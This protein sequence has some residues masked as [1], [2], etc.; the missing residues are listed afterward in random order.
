MNL[1]E[2][3][4]ALRQLRLSGMAQVLETR[5]LQ[6]QKDRMPPI[7][8]VASLEQDEIDVRPGRL[9]GRRHKQAGFGDAGHTLDNFDFAF[10]PKM[11]CS[12]VF[13]LATCTFIGNREDSLSLGPGCSGKSHLA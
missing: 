12:L 3:D 10:D 4:R 2:L 1:T 8:L 5:L 13:D 6:A 11:N 9:L 7:D